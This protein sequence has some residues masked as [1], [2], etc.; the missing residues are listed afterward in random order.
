MLL[1]ATAAKFKYKLHRSHANGLKI[2]LHNLL[3]VIPT[4]TRQEVCLDFFFLDILA[5][6]LKD[7]LTSYLAFYLTDTYS[8]TLSDICF[9]ILSG[10]Y[11]GIL[12]E[13][14]YGI[15]SDI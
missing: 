8:G 15:L 7:I 6:Y 11:P 14:F 4:V 5:L 1:Q 3:R 10:I 2:Q 9:D 12:S 13:I